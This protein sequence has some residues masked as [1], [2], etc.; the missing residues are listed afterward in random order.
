VSST[1]EGANRAAGMD[2]LLSFYDNL[3][4]T[5]YVAGTSDD[6]PDQGGSRLSYRGQVDYNADRYGLQLE[7]LAL[8]SEF[9]PDSGFLRRAAFVRNTAYGRFSPRPA[10]RAV[11][12]LTS[13]GQIDYITSPNGQLESRLVQ[14]GFRVEFQ[15]GDSAAIEAAHSFERLDEPFDIATDVTIP[16]GEYRFPEAHA[17]YFFGPQRKITGNVMF[18]HGAFYGGTRTHLGTGRGRVQLTSQLSVEPGV[19]IDW[20]KLPQGDFTNTLVSARVSYTLSPR[21]SAGALTQ[22]NSSQRSMN[23]SARFRWEY[24]PGSDLFVVF[25]DNRDTAPAGFPDLRNRGIVVK[26]TRLFRL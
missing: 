7:R 12:K 17:N 9:R 18:E 20:V 8:G 5:A 11:R 26:L 19:A 24:Q 16:V 2:A 23:T 15:N 21:M 13:D 14:A 22:Y 3:N 25:T 1:G 6:R 10:S 4:I